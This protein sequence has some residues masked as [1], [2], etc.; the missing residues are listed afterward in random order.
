MKKYATLQL[1]EEKRKIEEEERLPDDPL[2]G[3][4]VHY[5]IVILPGICRSEICSPFFVDAASG[6][7]YSLD[8]P[9]FLGIEFIWNDE[10]LW[11]CHNSLSRDFELEDS[12]KWVPFK[13]REN[14][15][16]IPLSWME[17]L[18]ISNKDYQRRF[19][20]ERKE[21]LY[22]RCKLIKY[23]EYSRSDGLVMEIIA[24]SDLNWQD[25]LTKTRSFKHRMDFLYKT[26]YDAK[27][28][29]TKHY[30]YNGRCDFVKELIFN[31]VDED[32]REI[33]FYGKCHPLSLQKIL[34]AK[35]EITEQF[36]ENSQESC[37]LKR[38]MKYVIHSNSEK[39]IHW[40][41]EYFSAD[42]K[43]PKSKQIAQ[44][45]FFHLEGKIFL[46]FHKNSDQLT[47][48]YFHFVK[49][50]QE[51]VETYHQYMPHQSTA[52]NNEHNMGREDEKLFSEQINDEVK[53]IAHAQTAFVDIDIMLKKLFK[54]H[55]NP[56]LK[57]SVFDEER[58]L[59]IV[60]DMNTKER[61]LRE[62]YLSELLDP[63]DAPEEL[64]ERK[65]KRAGL[66]EIVK[67]V[68]I[69]CEQVL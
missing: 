25:V 18:D 12:T 62:K 65:V 11:F 5:W 66:P 27:S 43:K 42:G 14:K 69:N 56:L 34:I 52:S 58:N 20:G 9:N 17:R 46:T 45:K 28:K 57:S 16:E 15:I 61:K 51:K 30:Y 36:L 32:K 38:N 37:L 47:A 2:E 60:E 48:G 33:L 1:E 19:Y 53:I 41:E 13:N 40:T 29:I 68:K 50:V 21:I 8:D 26:E 63:V 7:P 23:S 22:L 54:E 4:R 64:A 44:R 31:S 6:K 39:I 35:N 59:D 24:Y 55:Q 10:N 49:P 3:R 67:K